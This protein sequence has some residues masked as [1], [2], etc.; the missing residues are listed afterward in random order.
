M[1]FDFVE[2]LVPIA[3]FWYAYSL[4]MLKP[5]YDDN[6]RGFPTRRAKESE[7]IWAYVQRV[8]GISCIVMG[9]VQVAG[10]LLL[11]FVF[12]GNELAYWINFGLKGVCIVGIFPLVNIL[13]NRKFPKKHSGSKKKK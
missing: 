7:K 1:S 4:L 8:A 2:F 12:P 11:D 13:T 3:F 6:R 9:A 5:G 10:I